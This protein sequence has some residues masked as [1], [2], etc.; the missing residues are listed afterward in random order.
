[1]N[2]GL[3][4]GA[5]SYDKDDS[6]QHLIDSRIFVFV[7]RNDNYVKPEAVITGGYS[8]DTTVFG[9]LVLSKKQLKCPFHQGKGA[10]TLDLRKMI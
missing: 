5:R 2:D 9:D 7:H 10:V 4:G 3:N 6:S 8:T 1:M